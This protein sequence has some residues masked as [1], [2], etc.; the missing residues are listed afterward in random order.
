MGNYSVGIAFYPSDAI[1]PES[2]LKAADLALYRAKDGGRNRYVFYTG[3]LRETAQQRKKLFSQGR[4]GLLRKEFDTHLQ[5]IVRLN[6]KSLIG[7]EALIRWQ[8]PDEGLLTPS[9][10]LPLLKDW[11]MGEALSQFVL[12]QVIQHLSEWPAIRVSVNLTTGQLDSSSYRLSRPLRI[13]TSA[14]TG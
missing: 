4:S 12:L 9:H 10:I 13:A 5:P 7:F 1:S 2:L 6:D 11:S 8:H 3:S 14:I